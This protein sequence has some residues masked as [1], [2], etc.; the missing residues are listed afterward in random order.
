MS[1]KKYT[2][3]IDNKINIGKT[4]ITL[5]DTQIEKILNSFGVILFKSQ[6]YS[7]TDFYFCKGTKKQIKE[8]SKLDFVDYI[9]EY[10]ED[11]FKINYYANL[12]E[13]L[14][15]DLS[16]IKASANYD[17]ETYNNR[18]KEIETILDKLKKLQ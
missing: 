7:D 12:I 9:E 5:D 6:F 1:S 18:I 4:T 8:I 13:N 11:Y 14:V 3:Y 2:L 16:D 17:K 10:D 15:L